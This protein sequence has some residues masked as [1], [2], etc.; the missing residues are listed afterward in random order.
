MAHWNLVDRFDIDDGELDSVS[1][2]QAFVLGV[3][4]A[5]FRAN[6]DKGQPFTSTINVDNAKRLI[7]LA[8]RHGW[9]ATFSVLSEAWVEIAAVPEV[10]R[11]AR[12]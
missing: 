7:G 2:S 11:V 5:R 9:R 4:W 12:G 10:E 6:L 3:E 8:Q 1:R